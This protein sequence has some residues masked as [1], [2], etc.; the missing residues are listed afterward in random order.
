MPEA[1]QQAYEKLR[2][3]HETFLRNVGSLAE[4]LGKEAPQFPEEN[5]TRA[6]VSSGGI[7]RGVLQPQGGV[8]A[9]SP[10]EDEERR[11]A[12]ALTLPFRRLC[13]CAQRAIIVA[14]RLHVVVVQSV[15]RR[16]SLCPS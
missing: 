7:G 8:G 1:S 11:A 3:T 10:F 14:S 13:A 9:E 16:L 15:R 4:V 5:V 2:R 12:L 6:E